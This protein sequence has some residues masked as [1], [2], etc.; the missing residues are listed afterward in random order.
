MFDWRRNKPGFHTVWVG[1]QAAAPW[2][3]L[4]SG[5]SSSWGFYTD[6]AI[7]GD[8]NGGVVFGAGTD[9][10]MAVTYLAHQTLYKP[11][12]AETQ[13]K[14]N[15]PRESAEVAVEVS[16]L[17]QTTHYL[18]ERIKNHQKATLIFPRLPQVKTI[19]LLKSLICLFSLPG[20]RSQL[21]GWGEVCTSII[22]C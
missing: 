3:F 18:Y 2:K 11:G 17:W 10:H 4:W 22:S 19:K 20:N 14:G 13:G 8:S 9:Q 15:E 6:L 21:P 12:S 5:K 7:P 16:V 1:G